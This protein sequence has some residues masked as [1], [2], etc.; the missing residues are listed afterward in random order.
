MNCPARRLRDLRNL[1]VKTEEM[2]ARVGIFSVDQ[3]FRADPFEIYDQLKKQVPGTS[4][5]AL[6]ALIGA[7]D[8]QHW[9]DVKR[10]RRTEILV[11]LDDM[12]IAPK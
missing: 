12:G 4:M 10:D 1:G 7:I 9:L 6:Y 11:R 2:L 5:A 3:L 8:D